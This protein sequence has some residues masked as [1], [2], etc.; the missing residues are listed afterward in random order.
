MKI[1]ISKISLNRIY[2][3]LKKGELTV[4]DFYWNYYKPNKG[5]IKEFFPIELIGNNGRII[6]SKKFIREVGINGRLYYKF[7]TCEK[8]YYIELF[9]YDKKIA[10]YIIPYKY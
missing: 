8:V 3:K 6:I 7:H 4:D 2:N 5:K 1:I 9:L 10:Q